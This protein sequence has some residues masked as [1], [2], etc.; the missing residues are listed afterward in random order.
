MT[1]MQKQALENYFESG[2]TNQTLAATDAGYALSSA[3]KVIP[4]LLSRKPIVQALEKRGITKE[5]IAK[6]IDEGL[7]AMHP[8]RP[9]QKDHHARYK[10]V[11]EANKILDNY[12]PKK[13]QI[14]EQSVVLHLGREDYEAIKGYE[15]LKKPNV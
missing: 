4:D 2:L 12:P 13:V 6:A 14:Q 3:H 9:K 11:T 15:E 10:F 7:K 8:M 5:R 1:R